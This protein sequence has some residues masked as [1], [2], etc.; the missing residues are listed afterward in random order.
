MENQFSSSHQCLSCR[1]Q[2]MHWGIWAHGE[3]SN[4]LDLSPWSREWWLTLDITLTDRSSSGTGG[5]SADCCGKQELNSIDLSC[6]NTPVS[7][8]TV[9]RASQRFFRRLR[10]DNTHC[11][12]LLNKYYISI[13]NV[14]LFACV[15]VSYWNPAGHSAKV[16][17]EL[18]TKCSCSNVSE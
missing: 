9:K 7:A 16:H 5:G 11:N 4:M 14:Q 2:V 13:V 8:A 17:S 3:K 1:S 10:E 12:S 18:K 15:I 6:D